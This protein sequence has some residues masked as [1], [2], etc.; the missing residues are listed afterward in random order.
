MFYVSVLDGMNKFVL[1]LSFCLCFAV[2]TVSLM[3]MKDSVFHLKFVTS[4]VFLI[5]SPYQVGVFTE[6]CGFGVVFEW[7]LPHPLL[8]LDC[9]HA[10]VKQ[11]CAPNAV[12]V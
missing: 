7:F 11:K 5:L 2:L 12:V 8:Y 3:D 1:S 6:C 4:L 10:C 9:K